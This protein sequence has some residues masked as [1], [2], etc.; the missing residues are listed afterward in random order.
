MNKRPYELTHLW[1]RV[2][3]CAEEMADGGTVPSARGRRPSRPPP[4]PT[5][6]L[7]PLDVEEPTVKPEFISMLGSLLSKP[8]VV[9]EREESL[10]LWASRGVAW[11]GVAMAWARVAWAA[12]VWRPALWAGSGGASIV[13][14][15]TPVDR[16]GYSCQLKANI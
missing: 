1:L 10:G 3:H 6:E 14:C 11:V 5:L 12:G 8:E 2:A 13:Q 9:S 15:Y 7:E 16:D 4:T